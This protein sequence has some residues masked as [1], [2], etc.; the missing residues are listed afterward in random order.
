M[1]IS[2]ERYLDDSSRYLVTLSLVSRTVETHGWLSSLPADVHQQVGDVLTRALDSLQHLLR[3]ATA[4][5]GGAGETTHF[6]C[7]T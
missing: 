1:V 4:E 6:G 3:E 5:S 7:G 2:R